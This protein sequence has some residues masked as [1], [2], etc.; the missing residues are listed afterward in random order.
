MGSL[1]NTS[2]PT[3]A[4]AHAHAQGRVVVTHEIPGTSAKEIKIPDACIGVG[5]KCMSPY[6][7]LRIE[8][9]R[10]VLRTG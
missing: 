10:F 7:M 9:A 6:D 3:R 8:Q 2:R 4:I 5:I 1:D